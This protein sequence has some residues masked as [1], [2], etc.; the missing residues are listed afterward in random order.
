VNVGTKGEKDLVYCGAFNQRTDEASTL[1][2]V[3]ENSRKRSGG[4]ER[5]K[6]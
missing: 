6:K 1:C 5:K 2:K 3:H 4:G